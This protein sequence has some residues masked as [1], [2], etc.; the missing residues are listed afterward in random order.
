MLGLNS[1]PVAIR[2]LL[3]LFWM[4]DT[5]GLFHRFRD[6]SPLN[7]V[8]VLL[9]L[10]SGSPLRYGRND[11]HLGNLSFRRSLSS[12]PIGEPESSCPKDVTLF[13][14]PYLVPI[15]KQSLG[16]TQIGERQRPGVQEPVW[17]EAGG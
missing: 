2:S 17:I 11:G 1:S 14:E 5:S 13:K 12:T 15:Q 8:L 10:D 16:T 9:F 7:W 6:I 3:L 4:L